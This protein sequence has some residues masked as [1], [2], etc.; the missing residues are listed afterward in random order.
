MQ[1]LPEQHGPADHTGVTAVI[2]MVCEL[3]GERPVE[4]RSVSETEWLDVMKT[5]LEVR[6]SP[7]GPSLL[8]DVVLLGREALPQLLLGEAHRPCFLC[9]S[10]S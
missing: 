7:L 6:L 4:N 5:R 8:S 9:P 3:T 2:F 1:L 10:R